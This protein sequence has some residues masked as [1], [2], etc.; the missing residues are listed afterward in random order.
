MDEGRTVPKSA[1]SV[2]RTGRQGIFTLQRPLYDRTEVV[3]TQG[4]QF[5]LIMLFEGTVFERF[6]MSVGLGAPK[7]LC[8]PTNAL[9][10]KVTQIQIVPLAIPLTTPPAR[11]L[12][13]TGL[14]AGLCCCKLVRLSACRSRA[15]QALIG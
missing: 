8:L 12:T 5:C 6:M 7:S 9:F 11:R 4:T 3:G 14:A 15:H 1:E 10:H 2:V 13:R